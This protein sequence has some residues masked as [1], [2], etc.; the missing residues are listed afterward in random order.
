MARA[1]SPKPIPPP[2]PKLSREEEVEQLLVANVRPSHVVSIVMQQHEVSER[3]VWDDIKAVRD[4]WAKESEEGRPRRRAELEQQ[5]DDLYNRC[6]MAGDRK[7]AVQALQ[8]KADLH[9]ARIRPMAAI[10]QPGA[11]PKDVDAWLAQHLGTQTA[12]ESDEGNDGP[13]PTDR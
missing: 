5:A 13:A 9:G 7:V 2:T 12:A 1:G 4:R 10:I 6:I 3:Q 8:L 11:K